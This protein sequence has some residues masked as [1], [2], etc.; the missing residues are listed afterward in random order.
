[1]LTYSNIPAAPIPTPIHI[2]TIPYFDSGL[3]FLSASSLAVSIAPDAPSG[4]PREIAPPSTFVL[5]ISSPACLIDAAV[6]EANASFSSIKSMSSTDKPVGSSTSGMAYAGPIPMIL[7]STPTALNPTKR[8]IGV[9]PRLYTFSPD[10]TTTNPAPSVS[11]ADVPAVTV[12]SA[13]KTV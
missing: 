7:G 6:W 4:W 10:I 3:R 9:T 11:G 13:L 1:Y 2:V 8:A 12:P 5:S